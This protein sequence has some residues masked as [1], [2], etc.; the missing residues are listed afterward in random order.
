M[1]ALSLVLVSMASCSKEGD[2]IY[3]PDPNDMPETSPLVT[4]VYDP[5]ALGDR[6]YNDLI[7]R[8]V[9]AA[10]IK[11]HARTMQ[12][13]PSSR[14][15]GLTYLETFVQQMSTQP[16]TVRRLLIV[17]SPAYDD[18]VRQHNRRLEGNP[19]PDLLYLETSIPLEGK[20]STLYLPYYG[21]MFEAGAITP[22]FD[23]WEALLVGANRENESV[24]EAMRGFQDGFATDYFLPVFPDKI[25]KRLCMEYL[26]EHQ[27]E[28]FNISDSLALQLMLK[29]E[30]DRDY[31][32]PMVVPICGGAG[33]SFRRMIEMVRQFFFVGIDAK[34][35]SANCPCSAV[36]HVD[37]ALEHCIGQW[38]S[39]EGMPKHQSLG[40]ASG[41]TEVLIHPVTS[42]FM[43]MIKADMSDQLRQTIHEEAVRKEEEYGR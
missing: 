24:A 21:A 8:G 37:R 1:C 6:S 14:E 41:Y 2:I 39:A 38:L 11:Y 34:Q 40:L 20:G 5:D 3:V 9:E 32:M 35:V 33:Q 4:V 42:I 29:Y 23:A 31:S 26:G 36:K 28:G 18:Y 17:T 15:E 43:L 22:Y 30:W 10:A 19:Y 16:D 7:Y 13:S 25:H 12:L 27:D